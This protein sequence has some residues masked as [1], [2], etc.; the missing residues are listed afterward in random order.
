MF[1]TREE[2]FLTFEKIQRE[3][4]VPMAQCWYSTV[5][6]ADRAAKQD[7]INRLMG[8]QGQV[9]GRLVPGQQ[10]VEH[11]VGTFL[12]YVSDLVVNVL[13]ERGELTAQEAAEA[14]L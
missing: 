6:M 7:L 2:P 12:N 5:E 10:N 1:G 8:E 11:F 9:W 14:W 3:M 4:S 13:K